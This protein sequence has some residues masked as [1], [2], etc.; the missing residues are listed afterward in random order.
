MSIRISIA[1]AGL[2][3]ALAAPLFIHAQTADQI[4]QQ[5]LDLLLRVGQLQ[6]Q[7]EAIQGGTSPVACTLEAK[8]CPDGST[9]GR[10][11]PSCN[12]AP[13]PGSQNIN[14]PPTNTGGQ[15]LA[16]L[17]R[18]LSVGS[19][20]ADVSRLQEFLARDP[21]VY[22]QGLVTGYYGSLTLAAVQRWQA[23]HGIVSSGTPQTTGYGVV[24]PRTRAA[25]AGCGTAVP[26]QVG[27]LL[28][29]T[30]VSGNAPLTVTASATVNTSRSCSGATYML[31]FGD[32]SPARPITVP[33]NFCQELTQEITHTYAAPG[34]YTASLGIGSHR[35]EVRVTARGSGTNTGTN[36][37]GVGSVNFKI[38]PTSGDAPLSA[39]AQ[40]TI[41][42]GDPYELF[43]GDS[44]FP[45]RSGSFET[46]RQ[47]LPLGSTVLS[48]NFETRSFTHTYNAPGVYTGTLKVGSYEQE[49]NV[50]VW[51]IRFYTLQ[52]RVTGD[53]TGG[54]SVSVSPQSV[55]Q[56]GN[57]AISWNAQNAP[58]GSKVRLEV[59]PANSQV[60]QGNNDYGLASA[61]AELPVSGSY[62]WSIPYNPAAVLADAGHSGIRLDP[63]Q[64][65]IVAKLYSGGT[66]WGF[67][68]PDSAQRTV[69]RIGQSATF[70]ITEG[71]QDNSGLPFTVSA[72][73]NGNPRAF[74]ANFQIGAPCHSYSLNW[75][76]GSTLIAQEGANATCAQVVTAKTFSHTYNAPG[77]YTIVLKRGS[78]ALNSLTNERRVTVVISG[79]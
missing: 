75:G 60:A 19:E 58:Q 77:T 22:P 57:L 63:G 23:K 44:S 14:N 37:G 35:T 54:L 49:G 66:C 11:G 31:N 40:F 45:A 21:S 12:F 24:G 18:N 38:T 13:C 27:G 72:G 20:G 10:V 5:I 46:S 29:V 36:T 47:N 3:A 34:T 55:S 48:Q 2:I 33:A 39:T 17:A 74:E 78:G 65:K 9:V 56:G 52:V 4:Q 26:T 61:T 67:C 8:I 6:Q 32:G 15:C 68:T 1:L 28:R 70:T 69:H 7:L 79:S 76:D 25:M 51:R 16:G 30:P 59:Y 64:Y 41:R 50:L 53:A 73:I 43:W 62:T 71:Q 42:S